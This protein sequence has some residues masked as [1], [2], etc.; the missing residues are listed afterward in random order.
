MGFPMANVI[1]AQAFSDLVASLLSMAFVAWGFTALVT[2]LLASFAL[3]R[4]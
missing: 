4:D 3:G 1:L 2:L